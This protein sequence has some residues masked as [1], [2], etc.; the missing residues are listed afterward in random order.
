[1]TEL[2]AAQ[3]KAEVMQVAKDL[4]AAWNAEDG[5]TGLSFFD[6]QTLNDLWGEDEFDSRESFS[7]MWATIWETF[8]SWDGEWDDTFVKVLSPN[9][10]LFRGRYHCTLTDMN[11]VATNYRPHWTTLLERRADGWKMT[12]VDH[13]YGTGE[14]VIEEG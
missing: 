14:G 6:S 1:M 5:E 3:V 8:P 11:G 10:A 9:S 12:V 2:A 4:M 7:E 13:A